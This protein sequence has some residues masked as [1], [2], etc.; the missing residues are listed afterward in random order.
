MSAV[1][2]PSSDLEVRSVIR[3]LYLEK[4]SPIEIHRRL[5]GVYGPE[6]M[7]IQHVRK[8]CRFYKEGREELQDKVR[9]GRPSVINANLV[10]RV[11]EQLRS[12]RRQTLEELQ[13]VFPDVSTS[14]I[15]KIIFENLK[16]R[17]LCARWVPKMLTEE[18]KSQ[19]IL[20]SSAVL[21]RY[22]EEG[23]EFLSNLVTGDETWVHYDTPE[24]KRA[25]MQWKHADSPRTVKFKKMASFKKVMV[26][27]FWDEKGP[28]LIDFLPQGHT[29]NGDRYR[30]TLTKLRK[31]LK[32]RRR[33]GKLSRGIEFLHD[34]A[35]PHTATPTLAL[36]EKFKWKIVP[37]PPYSPDLAPSDYFLFP[38]LKSE[39]A[40]EHF[41][42]EEELKTAVENY[43]KN[44]DG[45][46]YKEGISK[47]IYRLNK[48][49]KVKGDY[50]E[51]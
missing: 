21:K 1:A 48:C 44:L 43:L 35:R 12:D 30:E 49:I 17:K 26:T 13:N 51:K 25:S 36:L 31:A 50:V 14:T 16:Y 27:V 11:D 20:T 4:N 39:L 24:T 7:S 10:A 33:P 42:N 41:D 5:V 46:A 6:A 45:S 2:K 37:H 28:I 40:G 15:R 29:I 47:L 3:F 9:S 23:G 19:R 22:E 18:N 32:D 8:W 38:K 34:N